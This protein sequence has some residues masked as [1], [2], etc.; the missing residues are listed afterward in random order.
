MT[1]DLNNPDSND[2]DFVGD[3]K[4]SEDIGDDVDNMDE[5]SLSMETASF[6]MKQPADSDIAPIG[7]MFGRYTILSVEGRG[8][9]GVVYKA[10]DTKLQRTVALKVSRELAD[11]KRLATMLEEARSLAQL[12]HSGIVTVFDF[13][14]DNG[15]CYIVTDFVN[16]QSLSRHLAD[17]TVDWFEACEICIGVADAMSHAHQHRLIHRDIKPG[18]IILTPAG[19]PI[20]V[21]FGL[22]KSTD[23]TSFDNDVVGTPSYMSPEQTLGYESRING[24]SDIYSLGVVLYRMITGVR[25][26]EADT[27]DELFLRIA[28]GNPQPPRQLNP[29]LPLDLER[30][31]LKAIA[32]DANRRYSNAL[33]MAGELRALIASV[34][35]PSS[36]IHPVLEESSLSLEESGGDR[37]SL[38]RARDAHRRQVTVL[39]LH[40][41]LKDSNDQYESI[42]PEARHEFASLSRNTCENVAEEFDGVVIS[43]TERLQVLSFGFPIAHEDAARRAVMAARQI[44]SRI[45]ESNPALQADFEEQLAVSAVIHS[46]IAVAEDKGLEDA[47][48]SVL[49][50][51][52]VRNMAEELASNAPVPLVSVTAATHTLLDGFFSTN[53]LED[54]REW[55]GGFEE[56]ILCVIGEETVRNRVELVDPANLTPLIGRDSEVA[57]LRQR[58]EQSLEG[59]GQ[60]VLLL[61][62]AGLGKSRLVREIREWVVEQDPATVVEW[63]CSTYNL[64]SGFF[65]AV[66]FFKRLLE[67]ENL[68][69]QSD[70]LPAIMDYLKSIQMYSAEH[71]AILAALLGV[72]LD[73]RVTAVEISPLRRQ[74]KALLFLAE[75]LDKL[76]AVSPVLFVVEDLHW[77]DPSSLEFLA[78]IM[79]DGIGDQL[80]AVLTFRPEF[81]T[82]WSSKPWQTQIPLHKMT[83]RQITEMVKQRLNCESVS[84]VLVEQLA[85]R[86]DG[87]PLFVEEFTRTL[88]ESSNSTTGLESLPTSIPNTLRDLMSTRLDRLGCDPQIIQLAATLGREFSWLFIQAVSDRPDHELGPELQKLVDAE[89]LFRK[90]QLPNARYIFKHALLQDEAYNSLL[91]R[92][93]R[94]LHRRIAEAIEAQ[95]PDVVSSQPELLANHYTEANQIPKA[96]EYWLKAGQHS[97]ANSNVNEAI[98]QFQ[99]GLAL[100]ERLEDG[101]FKLQTEL[102]YQLPLGSALIQTRGYAADEV[103]QAFTRAQE[104]CETLGEGSPLFHVML[105]K[106]MFHAVRG[107]FS[108]GHHIAESLTTIAEETECDGFVME[109]TFPLA[110]NLHYLGR[111]EDALTAARRGIPLYDDKRCRFHSQY[112]GQNCGV[113]VQMY[114]ALPLWHLGYADQA[115]QM[116]LDSV[117]LATS[118]NDPF[119]LCLS[120]YHRGW[121]NSLCGQHHVTAECGAKGLEIAREMGFV[122]FEMLALINQGVAI[123]QDTEPTEPI[124]ADGLELLRTGIAGY[125]ATGA[126]MHLTHAYGVLAE[127]ECRAGELD[128]ANE[129]LNLAWQHLHDC[130][131]VFAESELHR[132]TAQVLIAGDAGQTAAI[133]GH[134]ETAMH[135]ADGNGSKA[136]QMRVLTDRLKY[137]RQQQ[138]DETPSRENLQRL[139]DSITEGQTTRDITIAQS[140]LT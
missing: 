65:P 119:S 108:V 54:S 67:F 64:T 136:W 133:I 76:S 77:A 88:A 57:L 114:G 33:D 89:I 107:E 69:T 90:G 61:G 91:L 118:L 4:P 125:I 81:E 14:S 80:M 47:S 49:L 1:K 70:R 53:L 29:G 123:V 6:K 72:S 8:G 78:Q 13:G 19:H 73:H 40:L 124:F 116:I 105:G 82:T 2:D 92:A 139:L 27:V 86:T 95:F 140:L 35:T 58:W 129:T 32:C 12:K 22:A 20:L 43:T 15:R 135:I 104:I 68:E 115:L 85:N 99:T 55:S 23:R 24:R 134:Y 18:N 38:R 128:L 42:D 117:N 51:G 74:E 46:G 3:P 103:L 79:N 45:E 17:R 102:G 132:I 30:I 50:I 120:L 101:P 138:L 98:S 113:A 87:V 36:A 26:F 60:F 100:V 110:N 122:F 62:D 111:F 31:C 131:E 10:H 34:E 66:E 56:T 84:D 39:A 71:V 9:F 37:S 121:L 21:D 94:A 137:E 59:S 11:Q 41:R 126:G 28:Q 63:R 5:Q 16:G 130:G 48:K 97:Q 52:D 75:W 44:I 106:W 109:S 93:R 96:V 25:P 112:T 83:K 127:A 7:S